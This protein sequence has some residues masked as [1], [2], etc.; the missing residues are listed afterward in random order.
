MVKESKENIYCEEF[1][2]SRTDISLWVIILLSVLKIIGCH[3][4][5]II[6]FSNPFSQM[7]SKILGVEPL[8]GH[9][10]IAGLQE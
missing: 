8:L 7:K 2:Q 10:Q 4:G 6:Y 9:D 5:L 3:H 1:N